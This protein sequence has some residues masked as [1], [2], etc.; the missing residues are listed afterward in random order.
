VYCFGIFSNK[1]DLK[2]ET[3]FYSIFV[4]N[5]SVNIFLN[6]A[7]CQSQNKALRLSS[8]YICQSDKVKMK[9][10][11]TNKVEE[12]RHFGFAIKNE[13]V[14]TCKSLFTKKTQFIA[15]TGSNVHKEL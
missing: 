5:L 1:L 7:N 8:S 15:T 2:P 10:R 14:Q 3:S 11:T 4:N 6:S 13:Y 12:T 9:L